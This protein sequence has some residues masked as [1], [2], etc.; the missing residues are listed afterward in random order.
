MNIVIPEWVRVIFFCMSLLIAFIVPVYIQFWQKDLE[1]KWKRNKYIKYSIVIIS[2]FIIVIFIFS[3]FIV[4]FSKRPS[5]IFS[6]VPLEN[7]YYPSIKGL[8]DFGYITGCGEDPTSGQKIFCPASET[9][10][11]EFGVFVWRLDYCRSQNIINNCDLSK[12]DPIIFSAGNPLCELD[13]NN[14]IIVKNFIIQD[15]SQDSWVPIWLCGIVKSGVLNK[16]LL[17]Y[18]SIESSVNKRSNSDPT[19]TFITIDYNK[20]IT[21]QDAAIILSNYFP[22]IITLQQTIANYPYFEI[23]L[24]GENIIRN[25]FLSQ[26]VFPDGSIGFCP[27]CKVL[28]REIANWIYILI[29][30]YRIQ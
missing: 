16:I 1:K 23:N 21:R 4:T 8:Y 28:R 7:R 30:K 27:D 20:K 14:N 22:D 9:S 13:E 3:S 29:N 17:N 18:E 10:L 11:I 19:T 12:P 26:H 2:I 24:L 15:G 6:D 25:D 5:S